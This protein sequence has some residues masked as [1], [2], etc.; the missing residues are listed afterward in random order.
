[1]P[2][3][4]FSITFTIFAIIFLQMEQI[5]WI[6][7]VGYIAATLTTAS[8]FPQAY[9]VIKTND[10]R[11]IS[12]TMYLVFMLGV[13]CW[14][15]YGALIQSNPMIIANVITIAPVFYIFV[16][17]CKHLRRDMRDSRSLR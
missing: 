8:Q 5:F 13:L 17:K 16:M 12:L 10:T 15:A 4:P 3:S 6:E 9:K 14:L 1:M 2:N 7:V 11:S